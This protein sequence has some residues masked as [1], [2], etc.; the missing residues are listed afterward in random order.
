M[1]KRDLTPSDYILIA[2]NLLPIIGVWTW[3]WNPKEIFLVYCLESIIMGILTLTKMGIVTIIRK[4]DNWYN[5]GSTTQQSGLFFMLFFLV[6]YGI[7]VG[8]QMSIFFSV[9]G[10]GEG[11]HINALNFFY[12]WPG[13]LSIDSMLML[14]SFVFCYGFKM[15]VDFLYSGQ[16]KTISLSLLMFQPYGRI[17]IQQITVIVGSMFLSYGAGKIFI[18]IFALVKIFFEVYINFD[19]LLNKSMKEM[20]SESGKQ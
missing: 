3:N 15:I 16:Y 13:L 9:S 8:V 20:E 6:H 2:V 10:F 11:H 1:F 17:F 12:K 18:L 19:G 7:F 5:N 4:K 14:G